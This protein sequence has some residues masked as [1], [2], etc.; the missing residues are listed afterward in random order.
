VNDQQK[1]QAI[2][3]FFT[4]PR[5]IFHPRTLVVGGCVAFLGVL[6][7]VS[8]DGCSGVVL[9]GF[10][11]LYAIAL[12]VRIRTKP[13]EE[14]NEVQ[15]VSLLRY[16]GTRGRY[17][18]RPASEQVV[19]WLMDDIARIRDQSE[20]RLG[21]YETTREPLCLVGPLYSEEVNGIRPDLVM[22]RRVADG[23]LYSTYKIT[24]FQFAETLLA[25]YQCNFNL[26]Q[27]VVAAE[28][29]AEFFYRDIVAVRTLTESVSQVLKSGEQLTH[30]RVFSLTAA[31]GDRIRIVLDDPSIQAGEQIRSLG[32]KAAANIRAMLRQYKAPEQELL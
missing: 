31:S 24:V 9:A 15:S 8:G 30:S 12:P 13:G 23:Y 2:R 1:R 10:G 25:A 32:D 20:D 18:S 17:Q 26:I 29:T 16:P 11:T 27:S 6:S 22:R 3:E 4:V 21:L 14:V 19:A 28:Q 5:P 7:A